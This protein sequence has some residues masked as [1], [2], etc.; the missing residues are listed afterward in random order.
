V[1][2]PLHPSLHFY[3]ELGNENWN[4]G[5]GFLSLQMFHAIAGHLEQIPAEFL[6]HDNLVV[7]SK[8]GFTAIHAA[9]ESGQLKKIPAGQLTADLLLTRNENGD[10]PLHAAA[11]EGHL[12]QIPSESLNP[13]RLL[14]RNY[15]G[16]T[17]EE[18]ARGRGHYDQI[19]LA[20]RP[21]AISPLRRFLRNLGRFRAPF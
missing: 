15:D 12:D 17:V 2:P 9:A 21:K 4:S 11:S 6:T 18:L 1:H 3:L 13:E 14:T 19:P 16:L 8:S 20:A 5:A 10:T 7:A